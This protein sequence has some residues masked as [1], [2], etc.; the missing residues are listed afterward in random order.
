[1]LTPSGELTGSSAGFSCGNDISLF[2]VG[3]TRSW[4]ARANRTAP[5]FAPPRPWQMGK[6]G[7]PSNFMVA[8]CFLRVQPVLRG[9]AF[10]MAKTQPERDDIV[11]S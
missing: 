7:P 3:L 10:L 4:T 9:R 8:L 2:D 6:G 1:M 5:V 11:L